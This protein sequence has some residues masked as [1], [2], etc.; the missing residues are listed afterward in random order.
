MT[1]RK[2]TLL[3]I[4]ITLV[5]LIVILYGAASTLVLSSFNKLEAQNTQRNVERV[6]NAV[7]DYLVNLELTT[8][9]YAEWDDTYNY[10]VNPTPDYIDNNYFDQ[11]MIDL[12][13]NLAIL[14][15]NS[16]ETVFSK[17]FDLEQ[18]KEIPLSPDL[19]SYL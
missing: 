2:K 5:G 14:V 1:L 13:I 8:K 16:G 6:V 17:A 18:Q 7:Q 19:V 10:V 3:I 12:D 9:D 4:G 11:N 15:N